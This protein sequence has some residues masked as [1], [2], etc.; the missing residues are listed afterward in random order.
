MENHIDTIIAFVNSQMDGEPVPCGGS[1]GL[2]Q[3][4]D[5][6]RAIQ[7][8]ATDYDM[9]MLGLRTVGAVVARVHSNL[10]AETALRAFLRGDEIE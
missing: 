1:S 2:S 5:A 4:E 8:T 6:V 9:S 7:N 3:I 10:I